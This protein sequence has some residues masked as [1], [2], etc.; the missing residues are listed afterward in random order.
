MQN[1]VKVIF[2]LEQDDNDY[3]PVSQEGIWTIPLG[4]DIYMID[5]IPFFVRGLSAG[6]KIC[7][8]NQLNYKSF[9]EAS[10]NS[11]YRIFLSDRANSHDLL[12]RLTELGAEYE[13]SGIPRLIAINVPS[14]IELLPI[15]NFLKISEE[16]GLLEY[17]EAAIRH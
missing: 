8:D 3:P 6:D 2:Q 15:E 5:N 13:G 14:D 16:A 9:H 12:S 1:R 11:T 7:A 4:N 17:E 10:K